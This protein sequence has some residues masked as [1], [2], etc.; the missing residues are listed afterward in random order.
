MNAQQR[1][2]A[3]VDHEYVSDLSSRGQLDP[4]DHAHERDDDDVDIPPCSEPAPLSVPLGM[5]MKQQGLLD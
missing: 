1:I 5:V 2:F 4:F 3:N